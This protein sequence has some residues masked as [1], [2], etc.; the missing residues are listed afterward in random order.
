M[1][2]TKEQGQYPLTQILALSFCVGVSSVNFSSRQI[3]L[4]FIEKGM[5][6]TDLSDFSEINRSNNKRQ[7][8]DKSVKSVS[9]FLSSLSNLAVFTESIRYEKW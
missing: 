6:E 3:S 1:G 4:W 7:L 9:I 2:L 8:S 5:R